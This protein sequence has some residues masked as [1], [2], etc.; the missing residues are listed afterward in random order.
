MIA[1]LYEAGQLP[2]IVVVQL[3]ELHSPKAAIVADKRYRDVLQVLS[4]PVGRASIA[5]HSPIEVEILGADPTQAPNIPLKD[6]QL[7]P[8]A[9]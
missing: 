9:P 3:T 8:E 2:R 5:K 6:V 7:L 1:R 4:T